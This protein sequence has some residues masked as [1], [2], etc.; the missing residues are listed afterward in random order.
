MVSFISC[1]DLCHPST[2]RMVIW[3]DANRAQN[4]IAAVSAESST[5]WVFD[6]AFERLVQ[7]LD[8]SITI[9]Y[10]ANGRR[11]LHSR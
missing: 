1:A 10:S 5:V 3:P 2:S 8:L 11:R 6:A 7:A 9:F 4:S